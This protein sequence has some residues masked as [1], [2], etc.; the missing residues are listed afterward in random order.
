MNLFLEHIPSPLGT[1]LLVS[2]GQALCAV[3]FEDCE[4]R[5]HRL[6]RRYYGT[7]AAAPGRAGNTGESIAAYFGGHLTAL[8]RIPVRMTGSEFQ[9]RVWT[10]LRRIPAG[11]TT[12]YGH[13]AATIGAP[14]AS[15]AVGLANGANPIA[16]VVPCHR[17]IGANASLTGY[18]GDF[19]ASSG[20]CGMKQASERDSP[21]SEDLRYDQRDQP[22]IYCDQV[23]LRAWLED[24]HVR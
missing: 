20:C 10:A 1:I 23:N 18:G 15:R 9:R 8:D 5:L 6:L 4:E 24:L 13:L 17:V 7:Y 22:R 11:T 3:D 21:Q 16:I 19:P 14:T 2:D 12:T